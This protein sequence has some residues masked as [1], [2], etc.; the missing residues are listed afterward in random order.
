MKWL[1]LALCVLALLTTVVVVVD[2]LG[3]GG[4]PWFGWWDSNIVIV[5]PY[6]VAIARPRPD[7]AAARGGVRDGDRIDLRR[8][9]LQARLAVLYQLMARRS[10]VLTIQRGKTTRTVSV[11]GST[12]WDNATFWK[13]QPMIS[14]A[15]VGA[16]F[17]L[18]AFL[19]VLRKWRTREARLFALVLIC[20]VGKMLDPSFI[21]VPLAGIGLLLLMV[22]RACATLASFVLVKLSSEFGTRSRGRTVLENAAYAAILFGFVADVGATLGL[23]TSWIDPLP[24]ILSLSPARGYLD[25]IG[26][27][28]V[29]LVATA[30]VRA[31]SREARLRSACLLLPLPIAFLASAALFT[32]PVFVNSWFAN[33]AVIAIANAAML[34]GALVVA[35]AL[36]VRWE[37]CKLTLTQSVA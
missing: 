3:L 37:P 27:L 7:G 14:R 16:W 31:T 18:C 13:L 5:Q 25:I 23:V 34:L 9:T 24:Y 30:A 29:L 4:P 10:T 11:A 22:S 33:I 12:V 20:V 1:L 35:Y 6:T 26:C 28:L 32:A 2:E 8:Q 21:V 19:I 17:T 15:V 36:L